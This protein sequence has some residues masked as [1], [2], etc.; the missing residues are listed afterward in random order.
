MH[1]VNCLTTNDEYKQLTEC[2]DGLLKFE[3]LARVCRNVGGT[4]EV[5]KDQ[6]GG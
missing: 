6:S 3:Y 4:A 5:P 1:K 2:S